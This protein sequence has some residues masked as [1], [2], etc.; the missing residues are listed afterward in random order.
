M[1]IETK[2]AGGDDV[3]SPGEIGLLP[4]TQRCSAIAANFAVTG[5]GMLSCTLLGNTAILG[6]VVN[7]HRVDTGV[8]TCSS[9]A[10][11]KYVPKECQ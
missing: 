9:T 6:K 8:W 3:A 1:N 11:A 5:A 2:L 10:D 7:W 4:T